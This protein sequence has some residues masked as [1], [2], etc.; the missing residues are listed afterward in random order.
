VISG[1][2]LIK[3]TRHSSVPLLTSP[4]S[5]LSGRFL[6]LSTSPRRNSRHRTT[7]RTNDRVLSW[8]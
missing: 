5:R 7:A 4:R 1:R 6:Q 8:R 3:H 2:G